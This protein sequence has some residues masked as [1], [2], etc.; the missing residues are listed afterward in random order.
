MH[1]EEGVDLLS[2][3]RL[4]RLRPRDLGLPQGVSDIWPQPR[5]VQ[6]ASDLLQ[7]QEGLAGFGQETA[8]VEGGIVGLDGGQPGGRLGIS[9]RLRGRAFS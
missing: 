7:A 1:L 6:L 4:R 3:G 8:D 5:Q 2:A 9:L